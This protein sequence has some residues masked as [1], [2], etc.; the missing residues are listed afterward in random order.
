MTI[1]KAFRGIERA[2]PCVTRLRLFCPYMSVYF[3]LR[4]IVELCEA[5]RLIDFYQP[6]IENS[7]SWHTV[8]CACATCSRGVRQRQFADDKPT[9]SERP[10][11]FLK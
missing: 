6:V 9:A 10:L 8:R 11:L 5:S 7:I 4:N 2:P 3:R 1:T